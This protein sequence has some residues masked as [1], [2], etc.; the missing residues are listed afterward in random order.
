MPGPK[1]H[2]IG[3]LASELP[4]TRRN[5]T[6]MLLELLALVPDLQGQPNTWFRVG[7]F[8][9]K[10]TAYG[11]RRTLTA[12]VPGV[13]CQARQVNGGSILWARWVPSKDGR[14]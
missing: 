6:G 2:K 7:E 5:P 9:G 12:R 13:E 3:L 10:Q 1:P 11:Y 8:A 4:P 14:R